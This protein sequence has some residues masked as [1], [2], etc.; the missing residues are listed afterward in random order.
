MWFRRGQVICPKSVKL[1][2]SQARGKAGS[3][4]QSLVAN[5]GF[6]LLQPTPP[7][8]PS[9]LSRDFCLG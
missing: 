4:V 9:S 6:S 7:N 3:L 2:R 1:M 8:C 5:L